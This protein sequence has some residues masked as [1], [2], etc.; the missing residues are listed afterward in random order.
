MRHRLA[1]L[2][3]ALLVAGIA[4]A[5]N[6]TPPEPRPLTGSCHCGAVAYKATGKVAKCSYCDCAGCRKAT[7]TFKAPFVTV[8]SADFAVTSGEPAVFRSE[9]KEK[10][11]GHGTWHFCPKCGTHL[12]WKPLKGD[13]IDIFAGTLD[14]PS[15]FKVKEK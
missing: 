8:R 14:D 12:F 10:C 7:G 9:S 11:N 5:Q 4:I 6:A 13:Q 2:A 3:A 1:I 15:V